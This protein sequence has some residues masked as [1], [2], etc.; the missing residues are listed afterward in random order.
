V[1]LDPDHTV[2]HY[3]A[4]FGFASDIRTQGPCWVSVTAD[5]INVAYR[6]MQAGE[7]QVIEAREDVVL[8][9]GDPA[10]FT[11]QINEM[12]GRPLGRAGQPIT[13]RITTQNY[14][15]FVSS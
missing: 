3:L 8:R 15:E 14:H 6:L 9:V 1:G 10:A 7:R 4:Q 2:T 13:V 5:G 12:P 11:F